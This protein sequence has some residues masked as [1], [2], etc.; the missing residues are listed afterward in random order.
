M[1]HEKKRMITFFVT[2]KCN[3]ACTYCVND[4]ENVCQENT[5][6]VNFAKKGIDDFFF[7]KTELFGLNNR[8]IRFYAVGEPT[9]RMNIIKDITNYARSIK[10]EELF[11]ELQTNGVFNDNT[12]KWIAKNVNEVWVSID[13]PKDIQNKYRPTKIGIESSVIVERNIKYLQNQGVFVGVRPTIHNDTVYR[14]KEIIDYFNNLGIKWI[15]AEPEFS[16]VKQNGESI[17]D[18]ITNI[19]LKIFVKEFLTAHNHAKSKGINY[20][21]LFTM[22]FDEHCNYGCR[23]C[24]PMPQLTP[25]GYISSC[26]LAYS[27]NT[28]LNDFIFG[29]YDKETNTIEYYPEKIAKIRERHFSQIPECAACEVKN[30]CGGGCA[31]LA[32]YAT[33]KLK[34][35]VPE[36]C[37]ATKY[38]ARN[39]LLN[40]GRSE[41]LHP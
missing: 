37:E 4:T 8:H 10:K 33:G 29:K 19:D 32:Y 28:S 26:D 24:L 12:A 11:V 41:H 16:S 6:D 22:N 13:G 9:T 27:G 31:G 18:T 2:N 36:F 39:L 1:S 23:A 25:D 40:K 35:I 38:L 34:G 15:Y 30:N 17:S 14:Q 21:N 5:L 3:L 7:N 20:G